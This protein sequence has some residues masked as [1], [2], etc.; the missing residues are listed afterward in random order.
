MFAYY[1]DPTSSNLS[2]LVCDGYELTFNNFSMRHQLADVG[3]KSTVSQNYNNNGIY[4]VSIR[5]HTNDWSGRSP[6]M[7]N[8]IHI[9]YHI[10][11]TVIEAARNK[12]VVIVLDNQSEGHSLLYKSVDGYREMHLAMKH[13]KLPRFSVCLITNNRWVPQEYNRWCIDNDEVTMFA[14]VDFLTGFFYFKNIPENVCIKDAVSNNSSVSFNSLNRVIR[15]HRTD[16]LY[17]LIKNNL[18]TQGLVS[19]HYSDNETNIEP[20]RYLKINQTEYENSLVKNLPLEADGNWLTENPDISEQHIFNH[21]IYK[22][23]LLSVVTET[24]YHQIGMFITEKTFKP[25][26]AGHPFMILGQFKILETLNKLGYKTEF[27]GIDQRYDNIIDPVERF[28]AFHRSLSAWINTDRKKQIKIMMSN[29]DIVEYNRNYFLK[30]DHEK[31]SFKKLY[32]TVK[33]IFLNRY[34]V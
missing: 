26:V 19:G 28:N 27:R 23:S 25:I 18:H 2:N 8:G 4:V 32:S 5:G 16:H 21:Q 12:K 13:L 9:L 34:S 17:F 22:N 10:P 29:I 20:S 30:Q 31:D 1:D 3:F 11:L 24:A 7:K 14:H 6:F 33:D 15:P